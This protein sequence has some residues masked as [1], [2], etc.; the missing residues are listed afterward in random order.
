MKKI[1]LLVIIYIL[2]YGISC[3]DQ[4]KFPLLTEAPQLIEPIDNDYVET[5]SPTFVWDSVD[6]AE[7]YTLYLDGNVIYTGSD[8][9][10]IP[11]YQISIGS[12][13]HSWYVV[14]SNPFKILSSTQNNFHFLDA[15]IPELSLTS[16][17][18][19]TLVTSNTIDIKGTAQD[20]FNVFSI[21]YKI[22]A[23]E[24]TLTD[25]QNNGDIDYQIDVSDLQDG[26][27]TLTITVTDT[28]NNISTQSIT[29]IVF[30][31]NISLS[32]PT[33]N[34]NECTSN[35]TFSF[36]YS[37]STNNYRLLVAQDSSFQSIIIDSNLNTTSYQSTI[38]L[39]AGTYYWKVGVLQTNNNNVYS[40]DSVTN[41]F[42]V[43]NLTYPN[44]LLPANNSE[45]CSS[46]F[47]FSFDTVSSAT[48]YYIQI[49]NDS[50]FTNVVYQGSQVDTTFLNPSNL[51]SSGIYYYH[52][53]SISDKCQSEYSS[54]IQF[55][56]YETIVNP[57]ISGIS[58]ICSGT[59]SNI[60]WTNNVGETYTVEFFNAI[61]STWVTPDSVTT[62]SASKNALSTGLGYKWRTKTQVSSCSSN[63]QESATFNVLSNPV[64]PTGLSITGGNTQCNSS[65]ITFNWNTTGGETYTL[66]VK[67][68]ASGSYTSVYSGTNSTFTL[69]WGTAPLDAVSTYNWQVT[70]STGCGSSQTTSG[71][72]FDIIN[73][74]VVPSGLTV[75]GGY[76]KCSGNNIVFN[77]STTA[78]ETYTL[79][80]KKSASA[81][82]TSV[83]SGTNSTFTLT[84]GTAPL[85][86]ATTYNWQVSSST[87]C[88]SSQTFSGADINVNNNPT[89]PSG[90][91]VTGGYAQCTGSNLT[92][93]W[94]T[95]AGETYT[96]E[97][98][99]SASGTYSPIFVMASS[100]YTL[101][102][103]TAPLDSATTYNWRVTSS[104][105]CAVDLITAG[106]NIDIKSN[107]TSPAG[108]SITG[109]YTQ[110]SGNNVTFN[111][112]TT[113]G[114]TYTLEAKKSVSGTY[115]SLYTGT[116]STFTLNWATVPL[117]SATTYN[118][119][120]SSSTG[121]SVDLTTAGTNFD[122]NNNPTSPSGL[123]V[124]GGYTQ[125]TG[126]NLTFNW[127]TT[128]GETYTLEAK[129][130]ASGTYT[131]LYTGTNSTFT[132]TW[133]TAPLDSA[134]TYNWRVSSSTGCAVDLTTAGTNVLISSIPAISSSTPNNG[135]S[136]ILTI[137]VEVVFDSV[138]NTSSCESA[139]SISPVV[140]GSFTWVGNTMIF[141]PSSSLT[142]S[143]SYT[144][145]VTTSAQNSYGCNISSSITKTFTASSSGFGGKLYIPQWTSKQISRWNDANNASGATSPDVTLPHS[146]SIE[147]S[148][149][150]TVK[151]IL[152]VAAIYDNKIVIWD[153]ASTSTTGTTYT[154]SITA[155]GLNTP[156]CVFIDSQNDR[157]FV[158][159]TGGT[160]AL[161]QFDN[162]S[163]LNGTVTVSRKITNIALNN[164]YGV[165]VDTS[166][167]IAY[168]ANNGG[169][170][171]L[172]YDN[173]STL[174]GS[175]APTR[176]LN[177]VNNPT[178]IAVDNA[179]DTIYVTASGSD[180]IDIWSSASTRNG[181]ISPTR[182]ITGASTQL[183]Q[184]YGI[185]LDT[186]NDRL[187]V[188]SYSA[189][190]ILIWDSVSSKNGNTAPNRV[191]NVNGPVGVAID[192]TR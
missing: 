96:L 100:T 126:S 171:I 162:A 70:S 140:A 61:S 53:K 174:N 186:F 123:S 136:V 29:V 167:D 15:E 133:G 89:S 116:N 139:F 101:N 108:L 183:N 86:S 145:G 42:N 181:T 107:P 158:V 185:A 120:I 191:L 56:Y 102:W 154:R 153:N 147:I 12:N 176:K 156:E 60:S 132:Q 91:S 97:I 112:N 172:I 192:F 155:T 95:T 131:S 13:N 49:A 80:I 137:K 128:A 47:N 58:D 23:K 114:E 111:W 5:Y 138:M 68:S 178:T 26:I 151:D 10:Y 28:Q 71:T 84:W 173:V 87:G 59:N 78:G 2:I 121:C 94:N 168:I 90:L 104:T 18:D 1:N 92:F 11:D 82:Y 165:T 188:A 21:S 35:P 134:T 66:E 50:N 31:G 9:E 48:S 85:D 175:I 41:S 189:N 109:G 163:T 69:N 8:T 118:W 170:N 166:R 150:D 63:W 148:T 43:Y 38:S 129:K 124:T 179:N 14:A 7:T 16:P 99:K 157:L 64:S 110:C 149:I 117:D 3:S 115:T 103:G 180:R 39:S 169:D 25:S 77:W 122:V 142:N 98:K 81:T 119:R 144:Y 141:T 72:N 182:S 73:S 24:G 127:S 159:S 22:G 30:T 36:T 54:T 83:Y 190:N 32:S 74:P 65:N 4:P 143:Q 105:G 55:N 76:T 177:S 52:I 135:S 130:S 46:S 37:G 93:N 17:I 51:T 40:L 6:G 75:T 160:Q 45:L 44:N 19:N 62:N 113:A 79:D 33:N 106:T 27:Y 146:N 161:W 34:G 20:N 187:F 184:P 164:G 88:G 67:K 125:C 57:T 152:Y